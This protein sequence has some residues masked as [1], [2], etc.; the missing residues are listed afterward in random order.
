MDIVHRSVMAEETVEFLKPEKPGSLFVDCT[1]G[2]GG[3]SERFLASFPDLQVWGVDADATIM[4]KAR[5]RLAPFGN[6]MAFANTW[7][8]QFW[9]DYS[10]EQAPDRI[11]FDLGISIFHYVESG[12]GFSFQG[13]EQ[14]DMRL[15]A[16]AGASVAQ[17]LASGKEEQ[18]A[19]IIYQF[20][21]ERYA[22][23]IARAIV[24][25][26]ALMPVQTTKQLADLVW[27][28]VPAD[29]RHGRIH[30]ATRTFQALRI[31]VND[32]LGRIERALAFSFLRLSPG[33]KLGV[34]TFHSLE[35]RIVKNFFKAKARECTCPPEQF[36]CTCDRVAEAVVLTKKPVVAG[37]QEVRENP[38]SRSAKFR[39][40]QKR[41]GQT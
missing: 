11:L 35:D 27:R 22:R 5:E 15:D 18:L 37:E 14:L 23:R 39:V 25:D 33:G 30:P 7:Y 2:E 40:L 1:L 4:A 17:L 41:G 36:R 19:D 9:L 31:A 20:G 10:L 34:I 21:E 12:R 8:D 3:H 29:Y 38:P 16:S 26:R 32:E 6:R 24:R 13:D 28:A